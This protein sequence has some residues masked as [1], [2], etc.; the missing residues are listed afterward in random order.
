MIEFD[1]TDQAHMKDW[2]YQIYELCAPMVDALCLNAELPTCEVLVVCYCGKEYRTVVNGE[3]PIPPN[4]AL[5]GIQCPHCE[6]SATDWKTL[7]G[8]SAGV[9]NVTIGHL[10]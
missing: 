2:I 1:Q 7:S 6:R 10:L 8:H 3:G 9:F 4:E 5:Q